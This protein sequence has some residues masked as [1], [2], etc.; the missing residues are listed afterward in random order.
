MNILQGHRARKAG[1]GKVLW[2]HRGGGGQLGTVCGM[3]DI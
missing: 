2:E 3:E 1:R